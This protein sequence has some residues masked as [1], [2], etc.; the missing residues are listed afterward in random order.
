MG[1]HT[2]DGGIAVYRVVNGDLNLV[3][4]RQFEFLHIFP[5]LKKSVVHLI[6]EL[7]LIVITLLSSCRS[8]CD[9]QTIYGKRI[10]QYLVEEIF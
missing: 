4:Y 7:V 3:S 10:H 6:R 8:L 1:C 5:V 9:A 2:G